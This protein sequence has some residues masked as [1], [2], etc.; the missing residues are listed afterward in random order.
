MRGMK[1]AIRL[2]ILSLLAA[3]LAACDSSP[4]LRDHYMGQQLLEPEYLPHRVPRDK[5]GNPELQTQ[6]RQLESFWQ[7]LR[8]WRDDP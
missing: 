3:N 5:D 8:F 1:P 2:L 4:L 7:K 6:S